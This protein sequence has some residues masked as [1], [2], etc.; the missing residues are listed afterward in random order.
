MFRDDPWCAYNCLVRAPPRANQNLN[1]V[2][3]KAQTGSSSSPGLL[4]RRRVLQHPAPLMRWL[5]SFTICHAI[6]RPSVN[7]QHGTFVGGGSGKPFNKSN[8]VFGSRAKPHMGGGA[9]KGLASIFLRAGITTAMTT[10][11]SRER[12]PTGAEL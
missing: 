9:L 3:I 4:C 1:K 12:T 8:R 6:R 5:R 2:T 11:P 10:P 7:V